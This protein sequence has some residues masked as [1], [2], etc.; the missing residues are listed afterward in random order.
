MTVFRRTFFLLAFMSLFILFPVT[1][2]QVFSGKPDPAEDKHPKPAFT[3]QVPK[4]EQD[5]TPPEKTKP[6][7]QTNPQ[8]PQIQTPRPKETPPESSPE[9]KPVKTA[10]LTF[11]DGPS[12]TV[13]PQILK[14]LAEYNI[15]ASFFVV[16]QM[17]EIYPEIVQ[18][19]KSE[20]HFIGNHTYSH[21]YSLIYESTDNFW[22]DVKQWETALVESILGEDFES[23]IIR[24]PGG[25]FGESKSI[26]RDFVLEQGYHYIDW[27]ALNGDAEDH[28]IPGPRLVQKLKE[29]VYN[30]E[31]AVILMHD[32]DAKA[33][34]AEALP[35]II[36]HLQNEGYV[37]QTIDDFDFNNNRSY[38]MGA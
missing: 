26:F 6:E 20:G 10:Y 32:T 2:F 37:F 13:T 24:F 38:K 14:I 8:R 9:E 22:A 12:S 31:I 21:N 29:T 27:N 19:I 35:E 34:T 5:F 23:K 33:T 36:D 28:Y 16:G 30:K 3:S 15:K 7:P 25:S 17:A 18:N 1:G 11:D 4:K